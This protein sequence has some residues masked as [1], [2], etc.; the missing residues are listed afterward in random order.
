VASES[1]DVGAL[2]RRYACEAT[3]PDRNTTTQQCV[4]ATQPSSRMPRPTVLHG[5]ASPTDAENDPAVQEA[6]LMDGESTARKYG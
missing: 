1:K 4:R 3:T 5:E 2:R 6:C